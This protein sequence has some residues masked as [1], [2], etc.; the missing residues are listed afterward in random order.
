MDVEHGFLGLRSPLPLEGP[1]HDR[2]F[3]LQVRD[4][5][6]IENEDGLC[7]DSFSYVAALE[8]VDPWTVYAVKSPGRHEPLYVESRNGRIERCFYAGDLL[9]L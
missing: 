9:V 7:I 4:I 8:V 5:R 3:I 2:K 1:L 6:R